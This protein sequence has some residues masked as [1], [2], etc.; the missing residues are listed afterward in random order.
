MFVFFLRFLLWSGKLSFTERMCL[1]PDLLNADW[2]NLV[3]INNF[4]VCSENFPM[5]MN[6]F[7]L[8]KMYLN[9]K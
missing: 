5:N 3:L 4:I 8:T 6:F 2:L 9:T 7:S 1:H